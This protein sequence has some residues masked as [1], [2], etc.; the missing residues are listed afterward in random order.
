MSSRYVSCAYCERAWRFEEPL[1]DRELNGLVRAHVEEL[2]PEKAYRKVAI[3]AATR[4]A[5]ALAAGHDPAGTHSMAS[6][7]Y[8][9]A[10]GGI[11]WPRTSKGEPGGWVHFTDLEL[12]HVIPEW[13]GGE[14]GPENVV[15][16]CRPCNR[17][18][19]NRTPEEWGGPRGS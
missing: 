7:A 15:L 11:Y 3:P 5:V 1:T 17:S 10:P 14:P 4:R 18:K 2:H 6:C 9:G 12:D 13:A 8:C 16:A 19:K